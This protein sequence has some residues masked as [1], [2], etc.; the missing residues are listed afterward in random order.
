MKKLRLDVEAL[1]VASFST[2]A[3]APPRGT[4]KGQETDVTYCQ[5]ETCNLCTEAGTGGGGGGETYICTL[6]GC[7][8]EKTACLPGGG[9]CNAPCVTLFQGPTCGAAQHTCR[10]C[11]WT[12]DNTCP[13]TCGCPTHIA[14]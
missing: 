5:Y 12:C 4:V 9:T 1:E 7:E 8:T 13:N 2:D 6:P 14:C 10:S 11:Q 3:K